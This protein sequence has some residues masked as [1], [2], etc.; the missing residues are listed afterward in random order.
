MIVQAIF[1]NVVISIFILFLSL[2]LFIYLFI[3]KKQWNSLQIETTFSV[4]TK[5]KEVR[6]SS[7][8]VSDNSQNICWTHINIKKKN[9]NFDKW[10]KS[11]Q[12]M[13]ILIY[14]LVVLYFIE[15][16]LSSSNLYAV[17]R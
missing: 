4:S 15:N 7:S 2:G 10:E 8:A 6:Q 3:L 16:L 12:L 14:F 5:S 1:C 13:V 11:Q 17:Y 9:Y